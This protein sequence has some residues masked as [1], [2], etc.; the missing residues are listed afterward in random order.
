ML[1]PVK[2]HNLSAV[3]LCVR[4]MCSVIDSDEADE[5]YRKVAEEL[6]RIA[7]SV[8]FH[9]ELDRDLSQRL[10]EFAK[11]IRQDSGLCVAP[12]TAMLN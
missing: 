10:R 4:K 7:E 11:Q 3:N 9:P 8:R 12:D 1:K 6:E 5:Y 2:L